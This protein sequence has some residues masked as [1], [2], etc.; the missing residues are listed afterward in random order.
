M[1]ECSCACAGQRRVDMRSSML[2]MVEDGLVDV[3]SKEREG[4]RTAEKRESGERER[5]INGYFYMPF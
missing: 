5:G 2:K 1:K 3:K 4:E